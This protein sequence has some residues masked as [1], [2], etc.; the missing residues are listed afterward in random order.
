MIPANSYRS[1]LDLLL[2]WFND[3]TKNNEFILKSQP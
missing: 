2:L 1:Y 3:S